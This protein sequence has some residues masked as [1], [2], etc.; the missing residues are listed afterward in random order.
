MVVDKILP[1]D[2]ANINTWEGH[3]FTF[4]REGTNDGLGDDVVIEAGK[5]VYELPADVK[6]RGPGECRDRMPQRCPR[7]AE[8]G[9]CLKNPGWMIVNCPRACNACDLL[10]PKKRCDF[11]RS[12]VMYDFFRCCVCKW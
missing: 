10:D 11:V 4:T 8:E 9:E 6:P 2:S 12:Y 1:G 3:R 5:T 7:L